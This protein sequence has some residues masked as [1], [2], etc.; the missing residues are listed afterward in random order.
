M[1]NPNEKPEIIAW[2]DS[3]KDNQLH[4]IGEC[5]SFIHHKPWCTPAH[6]HLKAEFREWYTTTF[7]QESSVMF[8][9]PGFEVIRDWDCTFFVRRKI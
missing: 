3:I 1:T 2:L 7:F 4:H 9:P 8:N 6:R 5:Y